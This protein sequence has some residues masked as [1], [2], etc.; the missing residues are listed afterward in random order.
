M[1]IYLAATVPL[2]QRLR[3]EEELS[4]LPA[5]AVTPALPASATIPATVEKLK[6]F[7]L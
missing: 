1:R 4:D 7:L 2:L 3:A 5:H 6:P